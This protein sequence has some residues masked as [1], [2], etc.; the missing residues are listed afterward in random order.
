MADEIVSQAEKDAKKIAINARV[1]FIELE[2][3]F[4]IFMQGPL[5]PPGV[6]WFPNVQ[7]LAQADQYRQALGAIRENAEREVA[8]T[9]RNLPEEKRVEIT[10]F[11]ES[12]ILGNRDKQFGLGQYAP[13][14]D[15]GINHGIEP[16]QPNLTPEQDRDDGP[17]R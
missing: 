14:R 1:A 12:I 17:E 4:R 16:N 6:P 10:K 5:R 8:E 3:E 2:N 7:E 11:T 15:I 9:I 13:G